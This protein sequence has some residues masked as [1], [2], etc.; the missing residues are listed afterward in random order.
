MRPQRSLS[1]RT[2]SRTA[3]CK[4]I[5]FSEGKNTEPDY[6][7]AVGRMIQGALLELEIIDAAGVPRTI[8]QRACDRR[9][10][11]RRGRTRKDSFVENDQVWAVFDRDEH[12]GIS[13]ALTRCHNGDV[14]VAFSDPCF[15]IWLILHF[16]DFDKPD[17]RHQVQGELAAVCHSYNVNRGKSAD[18]D[19]MVSNLTEAESRAERQIQRRENEGSPIRRPFTTVFKL[20]RAMRTAQIAHKG[21]SE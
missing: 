17:D 13:D 20:T 1:R 15:E 2:P 21:R 18:F 4:F 10:S 19:L 8:A 6:F 16:I 3:K 11:L 9:A 5:I 14:S 12:P 7:R